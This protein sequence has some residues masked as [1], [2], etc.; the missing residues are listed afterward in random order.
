MLYMGDYQGKPLIFHNIWSVRTE[1]LLGRVGKRIV[2][3]AAITTLNPGMELRNDHTPANNYV[4]SILGMA[5][6]VNPQTP[7]ILKE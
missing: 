2:G 7:E 3:H 6:L 5:I 1:D 4:N